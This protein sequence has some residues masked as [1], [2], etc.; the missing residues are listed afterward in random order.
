[1]RGDGA[2][3][4]R[5][6]SVPR[7]TGEPSPG[8]ISTYVPGVSTPNWARKLIRRSGPR[9]R[10]GT[11]PVEL[12]ERPRD[13]VRARVERAVDAVEER[14]AKGRV[15]RDVGDEQPD[16]QEH[17]EHE[18]QARTQRHPLQRRSDAPAAAAAEL[19]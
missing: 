3:S 15:G 8:R 13:A 19:H 18:Q 6:V 11:L 16:S 1:M 10:T 17:C 9:A 5:R 4:P 7:I 2:L 12:V 14:R